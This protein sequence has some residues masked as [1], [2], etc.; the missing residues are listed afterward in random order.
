[1]PPLKGQ[2]TGLILAGGQSRRMGRDKGLVS[3]GVSGQ[4]YVERSV[5]LLAPWVSD[6]YISLREEQHSLYSDLTGVRWIFDDGISVGPLRGLLSAHRRFSEADFLVLAVDMIYLKADH[7]RRLVK[8]A[9]SEK[10]SLCY[11]QAAGLLEPLV[12]LY[13]SSDLMKIERWSQDLPEAGLSHWLMQLKI[14]TVMIDPEEE[15]FFKSQN[16]SVR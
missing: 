8:R 2:L 16:E 1:M 15:M 14:S 9:E 3:I 6:V 4:T 13:R 5:Q 11:S 12:G 7:I 10:C